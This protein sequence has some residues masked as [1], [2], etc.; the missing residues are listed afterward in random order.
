M[1][2]TSI[3]DM[4]ES[5]YKEKA[6]P[7]FFRDLNLDQVIERIRLDWGEEVSSYYY[8]FPA[9]AD[10]EDYRREVFSDIGR[11]GMYDILCVFDT[12]LRRRKRGDRTGKAGGRIGEAGKYHGSLHIRA[13]FF[14]C[15]YQ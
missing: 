11:G 12:F 10:C 7:A 4:A 2:F 8:Y 1:K 5:P 14:V 15:G 13:G 6:R 9:D 3:L